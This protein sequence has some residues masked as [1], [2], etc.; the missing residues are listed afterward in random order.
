MHYHFT[1]R[2][3]MQGRIL[4]GH[5]LEYADVHGNMYGTSL[6]AVASVAT[7]GKMCVLDIDVQGAQ[8]V[9]SAA[10]LG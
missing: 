6:E 3:H 2:D 10:V 7:T 4:D 1:N 9:G 5:F 8:Q